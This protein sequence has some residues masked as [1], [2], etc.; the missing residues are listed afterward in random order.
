VFGDFSLELLDLSSQLLVFPKLPIEKA[1][2]NACLGSKP[3]GRQAVEIAPFVAA[4]PEVAG[5][6][7][8]LVDQCTQAIM[9]LAQA[10]AEFAG[11]RPL[12]Q[13]RLGFERFQEGQA[14]F[15]VQGDKAQGSGLREKGSRH[16]AQGE[17]RKRKKCK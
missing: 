11:K 16:R 8:S 15:E 9:G 7:V 12:A 17:R 4:V 14:G 5:L 2:G 10:D 3:L 1:A 6:D 13:I